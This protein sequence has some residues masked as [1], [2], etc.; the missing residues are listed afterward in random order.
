VVAKRFPVGE[1]EVYIYESLSAEGEKY[2]IILTPTIIVNDKVM[3]AGRG[4]AETEIEKW[5][6][7][8]LDAGLRK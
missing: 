1:V 7:R 5:I 6:V 8:A 3:A 4:T 2:G